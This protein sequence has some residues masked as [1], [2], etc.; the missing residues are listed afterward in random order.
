MPL[1]RLKKID[2]VYQGIHLELQ[3]YVDLYASVF[4]KYSPPKHPMRKASMYMLPSR[5][6]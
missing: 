4:V 1:L 5:P 3:V 6:P 2:L